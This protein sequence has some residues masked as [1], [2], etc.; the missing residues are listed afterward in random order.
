MTIK[1]C[2][3]VYFIQLDVNVEVWTRPLKPNRFLQLR[4]ILP[5]AGSSP[6]DVVGTRRRPSFR[7]DVSSWPG[8][9][10]PSSHGSAA[11]Q[12]RQRL[13]AASRSPAG[14]GQS[15]NDLMCSAAEH[16]SGATA[17]LSSVF[18]A[19]GNRWRKE[20]CVGCPWENGP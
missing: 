12:H 14:A 10:L 5:F 6:P 19:E 8:A 2:T 13:A 1:K 11:C 15:K 9:T 18:T 17:V 4:L 3:L 7:A 16:Y 20:V